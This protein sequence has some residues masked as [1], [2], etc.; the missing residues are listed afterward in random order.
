MSEERLKEIEAR[1]AGL[2]G[3]PWEAVHH[4]WQESS[5]VTADGAHIA[6]FEIEE[7]DPD[8]FED[9]EEVQCKAEECK[10][11]IAEVTAHAPTDI[12]FLLAEIKRRDE[13]IATMSGGS[14]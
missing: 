13:L 12:A 11:A 14:K 7:I 6:S 10:K 3:L 9:W 1:I 2:P 8:D 4:S 5:V